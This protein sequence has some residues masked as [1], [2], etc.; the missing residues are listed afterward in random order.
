M[1]A[2]PG[3]TTVVAK[4]K[5]LS[6]HDHGLDSEFTEKNGYYSRFSFKGT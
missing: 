2:V 1:P 5:R 4:P 6:F 3:Q